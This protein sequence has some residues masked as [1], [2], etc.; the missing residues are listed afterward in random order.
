VTTSEPTDPL[1]GTDAGISARGATGVGVAS[2]VAAASGYGVLV[3]AANVLTK[4]A[5]ADFLTFWGLVFFLFGTLGG[6]QS[7]VSRSVHVARTS[8]D[9]DAGRRGVP[10]LATSLVIGAAG[11]ALVALT[12]PWWSG[13]V[14]GADAAPQVAIVAFAVLAFSGQTAMAGT[15]AGRGQWTT[16]A[17]LVGAEALMRLT[18]AVVLT[19]LGAGSTGLQIATGAAAATWLLFTVSDRIRSVRRQRSADHG[20]AFVTGGG[21]A[22]IGTAASAALVVGFPVL[23]RVST[24]HDVFKL[25][26]PLLLAIQLTRAPLLI[27]LNAY[28]GVA[29]THFLDK[30]DEGARP[31]LRLAAIITAVGVVGAV[32]AALV[33]PWIMTTLFGEGYHVPPLVLAGLTLTAALMALLTLTGSAV[34]ALGK[35]QAFVLGWL[36]ATVCSA[37]SLPMPGELSTRVVVSLAVGPVVGI[38]VHVLWMRRALR[39]ER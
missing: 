4:A 30:R 35:H 1:Q 15:L 20:R 27:P 32:A 37:A 34:L 38:V 18:L 23:L 19:L 7:E 36:A 25:A 21:Q 3:L 28:Q 6:L 9:P 16:Y 2:L 33:G 13:V 22:M 11:A 24:P 29:I 39:A 12:S 26:A 10:I 31:L 5:N 14:L 8:P 17:R